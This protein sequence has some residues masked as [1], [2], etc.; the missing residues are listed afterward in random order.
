M[1]NNIKSFKF[2]NSDFNNL[3]CKTARVRKFFL[4]NKSR[5]ILP[6]NLE[7]DDVDSDNV[8][9]M[10]ELFL[11]LDKNYVEDCY[12]FLRFNYVHEF[13]KFAISAPNCA[14]FLNL[15]LKF[16]RCKKY[17]GFISSNFRKII[18]NNKI[19]VCSEINFLCLQKN[20][21]KKFFVQQ[22]IKEIT[23]R[24]N[25]FGIKA[26]IYTT[27]LPFSKPLFEAHYFYFSVNSFKNTD[28]CKNSGEK[29]NDSCEKKRRIWINFNP[30][31]NDEFLNYNYLKN[32]RKEFRKKRIYKHFNK[33]D[34]Y[35]WV[36]F[37]KGIK[38]A[39]IEKKNSFNN[40]KNY[41]IS[42]YSLPCKTIKYKNFSY[43][44]DAYF[45]YGIKLTERSFLMEEIVSLCGK[46]G[47]DL[48]YILEGQ[49][50]NTVLEKIGFHKSGSKINFYFLG[51]DH[52]RFSPY[53]NSLIFF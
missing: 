10:H 45:Y 21:R 38:Y 9:S 16:N 1:L 40:N 28:F 22:L 12:S 19:Y 50:S 46:L 48:L 20:L 27:G 25:C 18:I 24:L 33:K 42:F 7:W 4:I 23:R 13:I 5:T 51:I 11:L 17:N 15:G 43:F 29:T 49:Y 8:I 53:E 34:F 47:F 35:Y 37:I 2:V 44:Y 39:F 6:F 36:R 31:E 41:L 14:K 26:A 30:F 32:I 3:K 52:R